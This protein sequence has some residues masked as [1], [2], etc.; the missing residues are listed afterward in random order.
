MS[1]T[2][3]YANSNS[4]SGD[5]RFSSH[6]HVAFN[7][8]FSPIISSFISLF[9]NLI[10]FHLN[11]RFSVSF[12]KHVTFP[13]CWPTLDLTLSYF[14]CSFS[15][16]SLLFWNQYMPYI[17]RHHINFTFYPNCIHVLINWHRK[18][19]KIA[20]SMQTIYMRFLCSSKKFVHV[21]M[22]VLKLKCVSNHR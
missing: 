17:F 2:K 10:I 9:S 4:V 16:S 18:Q 14:M 1:I 12:F 15:I 11:H 8:R 13:F 21:C 19:A 6:I 3:W 5:I 22:S 7:F 20:M